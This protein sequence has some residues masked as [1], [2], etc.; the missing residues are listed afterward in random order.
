MVT[1]RTSD[2]NA[3]SPSS[4][5]PDPLTAV[6][7]DIADPAFG[8]A[9]PRSTRSASAPRFSVSSSAP[10]PPSTRSVPLSASSMG[11]G[12]RGYL[13]G[14][15]P[16]FRYGASKEGTIC[17]GFIGGA[18]K[19]RLRFCVKELVPGSKHCG[20]VK[21]GSGKFDI[22][23]ESYYVLME[24]DTALCRP[25]L[26]LADLQRF[27]EM[28]IT[29]Q[30]MPSKDWVELINNFWIRHDLV[31][32]APRST[33]SLTVD[34]KSRGDA[35]VQGEDPKLS[36][37]VSHL[38]QAS[39]TGK[40]FPFHEEAKPKDDSSYA[41]GVS[42]ANSWSGMEPVSYFSSE[43]PYLPEEN[44]F[45]A[46]E[47]SRLSI[48]SLQHSVSR[49]LGRLPKAFDR[50]EKQ[51]DDKL[52]SSLQF[53]QEALEP[54]AHLS[55]RVSEL[56]ESV[57]DLS[58]EFPHSANT[59]WMSYGSLAGFTQH[60]SQ[61]IRQIDADLSAGSGAV[62]KA[63][64]SR[65]ATQMAQGLKTV[66]L[67]AVSQTQALEQRLD[68]MLAT[69]SS[70]GQAVSTGD[71]ADLFSEL[72][73]SVPLDSSNTPTFQPSS[74]VLGRVDG[75]DITLPGLIG[76]IRAQQ[77]EAAA[78]RKELVQL[79]SSAFSKGVKL[80]SVQFDD[81]DHI[82]KVLVDE[83]I[84]P[85]HFSTHVDA[86]S[87]FS[88]YADGNARTESNTTELKAMRSA[89]ITDPTCCAYVASFRQNIP[90]YLLGESGTVVNV[91]SRFP[92][93]KDR[94]AW[95]GRTALQGA[96]ALLK[97][98]IRDAHTT[99]KEYISCNLPSSSILKELADTC[100]TLTLDFWTALSTHIDDEIL[101]LSK[102]GIQE[103]KVYTLISDELQII[104]R[105][106]F[107]QRMKMQVFSD[108]RDPVVY[109][110]RCIFTTMKAHTV[111]QEFSELGFGTHVLISSLFTRFLA[112][113]T[114]ANHGAGLSTQIARLE[115]DLKKLKNELSTKVNAINARLDKMDPKIKTLEAAC[116]KA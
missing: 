13:S 29:Q 84:N 89:G 14:K 73:G 34:E 23:S 25:Y 100:N 49:L 103:E 112:E 66:A 114:G 6:I 16:L 10:P 59:E 11:G 46:F 37:D 102:Y 44:W 96:R 94:E 93:L 35:N 75:E 99:T 91:G 72:M 8:V 116:N 32:Y 21:H 71:A 26:R 68:A 86:C 45:P 109:Y 18:S 87:I 78:L 60:L 77:T 30:S 24:N 33:D 108:S 106:I 83:G 20:D 5:D 69:S 79:K 98:A 38:S 51:I 9:A 88:H 53:D 31:P 115:S 41:G 95:E 54:I 57:F 113:Q 90:P 65:L 47:H 19:S 2:A 85:E 92:L 42:V 40:A 74:S 50:L 27:R 36:Y 67:K 104:F 12:A 70:G 52:V 97:Q 3:S 15:Q 55:S 62:L 111:M 56:E 61:R 64:M 107:V 17:C 101:T 63:D 39:L 7:G 80:G 82:V 28:S 58:P 48:N 43:T 105:Q 1:S 110:A 76:I 4:E 81:L 22:T